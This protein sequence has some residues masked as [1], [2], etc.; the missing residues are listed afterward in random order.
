MN[1]GLAQ[2][3]LWALVVVPTLAGATLLLG[4]RGR[5]DRYAPATGVGIATITAVLAVVVAVT[6]PTVAVPFMASADFGLGVDGLAAVIAPTVAVVAALVLLAGSA[7]VRE[8]RARFHG[9]MLVFVAAALL[10]VTATTMPALLLAW[11][12]M[13]ATSYALIGFTWREE[14]KVASGLTAFITTRAAD[15]GL[16]VAAAAALAGGAGLDL[17]MLAGAS[18]RWRDVL[19]LGVVVAALGKSA[20]LVLAFWLSRAMDGPSPVSAL[21]H[22]AA[23]VAMGGY[24]LLR[25]SPLLQATSW[26]GPTAAWAGA[27]STVA[28]GVVAI[29]QRDLKQLL[30][31]STSAQLGYVVMAGGLGAVT[32]GTAH[33]VAHAVTKAALFLAAGAWLSALGTKQLDGLRGAVAGWP[34]VRVAASLALLSLAGVPPFSLWVSKDLVLAAALEQ[35]PA[36]YAVGILGAAASAAY[37]GGALRVLWAPVTDVERAGAAAHRGEEEDPR[38]AVPA[39][40]TA[41]VVVLAIGAAG[42][43]AVGIPAVADWLARTVGSAVVQPGTLGLVASSVLSLCVVA[44]VWFRPLPQPRWAR[45]WFG[46]EHAAHVAVV[47]PTLALARTL[48]RADEL[49]DRGVHA[50][51]TGAVT[52]A[53]ASGAF[54]V[55]VVHGVVLAAAR[56]VRQAGTLARRPQTGQLH[57][58]YIQAVVLLATGTALLVVVR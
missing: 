27:L 4:D 23:M 1:G 53:V 3:C 41:S 5:A 45:S 11:E 54:D 19:A 10:T 25:L 46:L 20:Q 36:L 30:A 50:V 49:L 52:M 38:G 34:V 16:Y 8:S 9:L 28:L 26:A 7:D 32:A 37:A 17:D 58:Y 15:L 48:E 24:L 51:A 14:H 43:G 47:R 6:R 29:G 56:R 13:G 42:L 31:A 44:L 18:P 39:A 55:R 40:L 21:L 12:V 22:S 2:A 35:S 57:Q 33:L